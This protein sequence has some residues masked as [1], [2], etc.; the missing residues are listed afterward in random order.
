MEIDMR[1]RDKALK[2]TA[3]VTA[4]VLLIFMC[5]CSG[6][7]TQN[8]HDKAASS[9]SS[10]SISIGVYNFDTYNPIA[11][12][13]QSV[14]QVSA[15]VYDS[16][17][18][19]KSDF[20]AEPC[21][22][23]GY[24][25]SDGGRAFAFELKSGVR[26]HDGSEFGASDVEYTFRMI[27]RLE[28]SPYK[29]R[30]A[31]VSSYRRVGQGEFII[32][33][34]E[35]DAGFINLLD[36]PIIKSGTDCREN[37]KQYVP[38]GTG[39][40]RYAESDL[41]RT[42]RLVKN[43]DYT[44][45]SKPHIEEIMVKQVP[46]KETLVRALEIGEVDAAYFTGSEM[47]AYNPKGNFREISY[48]N[49]MITFIGLNVNNEHLALSQVRRALSYGADRKDISKNIF[50]GRA[51]SV[52]VPISPASRY[53]KN[54]YS[55]E[56]DT[57]RAE[58]LLSEAGYVKGEDGIYEKDGKKLSLSLIV[59]SENELRCA[60]ADAIQAC[61]GRIGIDVSVKRLSFA[62]YEARIKSG[63]YDMFAGEVKIGN[64]LDLSVFAHGGTSYGSF[65][66]ERFDTLVQRS[67]GAQSME[68]FER[69]YSELAEAFLSEMPIVSLSI[70]CDVL[71]VNNKIKGA[72]SAADGNVFA[73]AASW[74]IN[75]GADK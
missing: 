44:V 23:S 55:S 65:S 1:N 41:S 53:Y 12:V 24:T 51:Q 18:R 29:E 48:T 4:V 7:E 17:I 58:S 34:K 19:R 50:F 21:L 59:N 69:C 2:L 42:M 6:G 67:R 52:S 47:R 13:S 71:L 68:E 74:H 36:I 28:Q 8:M 66:D 40:Y 64:N 54:I 72:E 45:S 43:E 35:P 9:V 30:L 15:L 26:W 32:T 22:C 63:S 46:D 61:M 37:L 31:N 25:I 11:T 14:T 75:S 49:G 33:L 70:G 73:D 60:A 57:D 20:T 5:A 56:T 62:E 27:E 39:P 16:L 3:A 10:N 38:V